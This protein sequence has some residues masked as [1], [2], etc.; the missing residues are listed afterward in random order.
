M[1]SGYSH[2]TTASDLVG[3]CTRP[4]ARFLKDD[5]RHVT[6]H[7]VSRVEQGATEDEKQFAKRMSHAAREFHNMF[8]PAKVVK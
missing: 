6:H 1:P 7:S 5:V 3:R 4:L 2:P 8:K